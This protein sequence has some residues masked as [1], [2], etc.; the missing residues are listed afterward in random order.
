MKPN[1]E[2]STDIAT[3]AITYTK[4]FSAF[5]Q[6]K[7]ENADGKVDLLGELWPG[8]Y[9]GNKWH[10]AP[11]TKGESYAIFVYYYSKA[12]IYVMFDASYGRSPELQQS[13]DFVREISKKCHDENIFLQNTDGDSWSGTMTMD[14]AK[15]LL[16]QLKL[17]IDFPS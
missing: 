17:S 4:D 11:S 12:K 5:G 16:A 7:E 13:F 8:R 6:F 10:T 14:E 2:S 9:D 1:N 15:R 3:S